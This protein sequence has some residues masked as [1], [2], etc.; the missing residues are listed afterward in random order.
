LSFDPTEYLLEGELLPWEELDPED[1]DPE[2]D[3]DHAPFEV[4]EDA[5]KSRFVE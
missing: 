2:F 5:Q 3:E 4:D 1:F